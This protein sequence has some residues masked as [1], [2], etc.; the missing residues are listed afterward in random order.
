VIFTSTVRHNQSTSR[1]VI[2]VGVDMWD[3]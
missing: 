1:L 3:T 2:P